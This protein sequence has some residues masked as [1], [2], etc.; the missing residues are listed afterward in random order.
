[1][2]KH[3]GLPQNNGLSNYMMNPEGG[4]TWRHFLKTT[5]D[6]GELF[7]LTC[8][9]L[10]PK[11]V[12]LFGSERFKDFLTQIRRE[13]NWIVIDSPPVASLAD[14]LVLGSLVE[15]TVFVIQHKRN[16]R[17]LILRSTEQ[18]RNVDANLVGAVLNRVD[19][20]QASYGDYYYA[21]EYVDR[22]EQSAG[23][24]RSSASARD[25]S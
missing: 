7:V 3:L 18:L 4:D 14:T 13:F 6:D 10:P 1:M 25:G 20:K 2:H 22:L 8:G 15:M 17:D 12:E 9:P 21:S 11:P 16:D 5:D 19:L 24:Q 23:D